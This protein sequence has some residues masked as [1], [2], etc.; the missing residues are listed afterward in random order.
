MDGIP[1]FGFGQAEIF[2]SAGTRQRR[3]NGS[4]RLSVCPEEWGCG[5]EKQK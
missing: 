1:P 5:A 4:A 2:D 3:Q